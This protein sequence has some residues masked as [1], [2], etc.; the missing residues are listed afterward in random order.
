MGLDLATNAYLVDTTPIVT[1]PPYTF[2]AWARDHAT[3]GIISVPYHSASNEYT[4]LYAAGSSL[5]AAASS[6][7]ASGVSVAGGI[8]GSGWYHAGGVYNSASSRTA[9][10]DGVA[11]TTNTTSVTLSGSLDKTVI[12]AFAFFSSYFLT[13]NII[14]ELAVW[15]KA[16]TPSQ[17]AALAAGANPLSIEY[18]S[19]VL[20]AP[21]RLTDSITVPVIGPTFS[22]S[23]TA[24]LISD[25]PT[26]DTYP[27]VPYDWDD[28]KILHD[29]GYQNNGVEICG[30]LS[31][32][33]DSLVEDNWPS[34]DLK[35][36]VVAINGYGRGTVAPFDSV[37]SEDLYIITHKPRHPSVNKLQNT[38]I[39]SLGRSG[40]IMTPIEAILSTRLKGIVT[41]HLVYGNAEVY[42]EFT[43]SLSKYILAN[44]RFAAEMLKEL[45]VS[46][47]KDVDDS[48]GVKNVSGGLRTYN[49]MEWHQRLS[50][51]EPDFSDD[52]TIDIFY[53]ILLNFRNQR[54]YDLGYDTD[55]LSTSQLADVLYTAGIAA[56]RNYAQDYYIDA[57]AEL[58]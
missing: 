28:I 49:F 9:Y 38:L 56:I 54:Q 19:L 42:A 7:G 58:T 36:C 52:P 4:G 51:V 26:I 41:N 46:A 39:A 37:S 3:A 15:L 25:H 31:D 30:Y 2:A 5:F 1:A 6:A 34:K 12:G 23:G 35:A 48:E 27:V 29:I 32:L 43:E 11:G 47:N 40:K 21:Y 45:G 53:S 13:N 10:I 14:A 16:L 24:T 20:Y 33:W 8:P 57:Y 50:G 55:H 44:P 17:M 18:D 22:Q